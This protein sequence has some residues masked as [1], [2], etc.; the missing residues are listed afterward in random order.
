MLSSSSFVFVIL[1]SLLIPNPLK[2]AI[3]QRH[4]PPALFPLDHPARALPTTPYPVIRARTTSNNL[5]ED[6][7]GDDRDASALSESGGVP[8]GDPVGNDS[9]SSAVAAR[10]R[11]APAWRPCDETW[12]GSHESDVPGGE[13]EEDEPWIR[14]AVILP[15]N[16]FYEASLGKVVPA[17]QK[18]ILEARRQQILPPGDGIGT[19]D[20]VRGKQF[21]LFEI[22]SQ[23]APTM[24]CVGAVDAYAKY[25]AHVMFGPSCEFP[26]A[27]AGRMVQFW[28][29]PLLTAGALTF[30]FTKAKTE[31]G[32]EFYMMVRLGLSF[33]DITDTVM[34]TMEKFQWQRVFLMY[35]VDGYKQISGIQTCKNMMSTLAEYL[36]NERLQY[37]VFDMDNNAGRE[38]TMVDTLRTQ[39]GF[40]YAVIVICAN[41]PKVRE[42]LLAAEE[43]QM[44]SSGEYVFFNIELFSSLRTGDKPWRDPSDTEERNLRARK[45]YEALLTVTARTPNDSEYK[46]FS[47]E[48]NRMAKE[49]DAAAGTA[50]KGAGKP[51]DKDYYITSPSSS[52][53]G[54]E[55]KGV[56]SGVVDEEEEESPVS[57]FVTAFYD[58][59]ILY[60]LALNE[61]LQANGTIRDGEN[62]TRRMW[63][64]TFKGITGNVTIDA[65][66]DRIADYSLLDMDPETYTFKEVAHYEGAT[67]TLVDVPGAKIH[68]AGGRTTHPPDKPLCGFDG[69]LCPDNSLPG[70]AILSIVLSSVVVALAVAS[71]F[72]YRH[73]KLEAEI[74]SMTWK[75]MSNEIILV[76]PRGRGAS[77][78]RGSIHSLAKRGSQVTMYSDADIVSL[79]DGNRQVFIPTALY[80]GSK[81]AIKNID[82][83]RIDLSRPVLLELK[84]M[85]DLHHDHLVRFIGACVDP[86]HMCLLTEYCPRGSLQDVLEN[87]QI[88]LDWTF[89]Y[90]LM[91]DIVKGMCYLHGSDIRTHGSLKSSNCVVDGRFVL[92][93]TD[94]GL[95]S[96]RGTKKR[97]PFSTLDGIPTEDSDASDADSYAFWRSLLWT[98]PE[99]LRMQHPPP[100][101]TQ[102][103]DVYS[104]AII[105]HE[106]LTRQGPFFLS[107]PEHQHYTP[108]DIVMRVCGGPGKE[109]ADAFR[110]S[111]EA[112]LVDACEAEVASLMRRCWAEE[113]QERP[114]FQ[115]LKAAIRRLNKDYESGNILDNLLSRMEQ[116]AN[117]LE[118]LVE[119][120]TAD[121][122]EEKRKCEELLYQLLPKTVANQLIQGQSVIAETYDSVTI[123]FSDIVGFTSL[124]AASTPMQVVDLLN[125][126]YTCF[127]SII[128]HFDVYK[129]ETIG[130]AYMV[131]SGLPV[132][133]GNRHAREIARMALALLSAVL[134]FSIRHRPN[135]QLKLRI[136]LHTGPCVAGVVGLKMP[137][138]CLFGDTVNTASRM[139]SNGLPLKIHLSSSTKEVL[140][141]FGT[142]KLELRGE[143][144]M[145]GKGKMTTYWLT[146][147]HPTPP[148]DGNRSSILTNMSSKEDEGDSSGPM[149]NHTSAVG[150][151]RCEPVGKSPAQPQSSPLHS[152]YKATLSPTSSLGSSHH[153]RG[154]SSPCSPA[155]MSTTSLHKEEGTMEI[156]MDG[157]NSNGSI[158]GRH[159]PEGAEGKRVTI[160]TSVTTPLLSK[161]VA[162]I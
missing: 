9:S 126:L 86:P 60:A 15:K 105:V 22:D 156:M 89:R 76:Q 16:D 62:I 92:K 131:V 72:I 47:K 142:F 103:G 122:L 139:E 46:R 111:V 151:Q 97:N 35:N 52:A 50:M 94:F 120:R 100:E 158:I 48:V 61:T 39:I 145:K 71:F 104:F 42:I 106:I 4:Q 81:V 7:I 32:S 3:R 133:N 11:E 74:A 160:D 88:T 127:D 162:N 2:A 53:N 155:K 118:A 154:A 159:A 148:Q 58:A 157:L 96:L 27:C 161:D 80:K 59:V 84:K 95:H 85:K 130:D 23:C 125:D 87:E 90:S 54:T 132:S 109:G 5:L 116:Y 1:A 138:Y 73:Y 123:Y 8:E 82:K 36:K 77:G 24:G 121:Y 119:E 67:R 33:R 14:A 56:V 70:Y 69:S 26:V 66:G 137:R 140:D 128:E 143:V 40:N 44:V 144:E 41:P 13:E 110:P 65:N 34:K 30:D 63:N 6:S 51:G 45:A 25:C 75:V 108:K 101:G 55:D 115:A 102:R 147:E 153:F 64:R 93:I 99:L 10:K 79:G 29:I 78:P 12:I 49:K 18:A 152:A 136:G 149:C 107:C 114:D 31:P 129:V 146:G 150:S 117:N 37:G 57:T 124:S 91:H 43:L 21:K 135:E 83:S 134:T 112:G 17:L 20:G 98:A 68:W 28:N 141:T 19:G 38:G 113:P